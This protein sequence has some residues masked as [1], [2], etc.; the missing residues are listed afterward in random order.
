[1]HNKAYVVNLRRGHT[2][3]DIASEANFNTLNL[4]KSP[5]LGK[6]ES[7]CDILQN[8]NVKYTY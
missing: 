7:K 4:N 6:Y 2:Q 5:N 8:D 1:M 3:H